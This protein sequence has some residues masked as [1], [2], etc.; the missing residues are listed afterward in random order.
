MQKQV[1]EN[2]IGGIIMKKC[3]YTGQ[4]IDIRIS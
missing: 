2:H 3:M 4:Y 1:F